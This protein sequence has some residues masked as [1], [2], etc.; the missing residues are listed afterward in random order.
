MGAMMDLEPQE[1]TEALRTAGDAR[2]RLLTVHLQQRGSRRAVTVVAA[3]L[4]LNATFLAAPD[5][6]GV[7]RWPVQ[8]LALAVLV[9]ALVAMALS[10]E[11]AGRFGESVRLRARALPR[12]YLFVP[13]LLGLTYG[14]A[15][16][17]VGRWSDATG[18]RYPHVLMATVMTV[19]LITLMLAAF[20]WLR[21][22][23]AR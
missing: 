12:R 13:L 10:R 5:L 20:A 17:F 23:R 3:G 9:S 19:L 18:V 6:P 14:A 15:G 22:V 1:A 16:P 21:A 8:V 2:D 4:L 11:V 7:W